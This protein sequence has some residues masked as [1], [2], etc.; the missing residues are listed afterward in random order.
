MI[1]MISIFSF[2]VQVEILEIIVIL[3]EGV[4]LT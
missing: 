4:I 3:Y 2:L 1:I